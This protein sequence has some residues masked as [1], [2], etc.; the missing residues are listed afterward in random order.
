MIKSRKES[1]QLVLSFFIWEMIYELTY[2]YMH[3]YIF[4][5]Q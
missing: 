3:K 1:I 5:S 4:L 2:I